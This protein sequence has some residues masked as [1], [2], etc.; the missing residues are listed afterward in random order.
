[1]IRRKAISAPVVR[2]SLAIRSDS[3]AI[4]KTRLG[5]KVDSLSFIFSSNSELTIL[6]PNTDRIVEISADLSSVVLLE[7]NDRFQPDAMIR[8][9]KKQIKDL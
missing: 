8:E 9:N 5:S 1:V 2:F 3:E 4:S 7:A 6:S